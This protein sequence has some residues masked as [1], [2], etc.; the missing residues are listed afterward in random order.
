MHRRPPGSPGYHPEDTVHVVRRDELR[1]VDNDGF[2]TVEPRHPWLIV[3][4]RRDDRLWDEA[5]ADWDAFDD[6]LDRLTMDRDDAITTAHRILGIEEHP[7][8]P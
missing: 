2:Y 7:V 8:R 6:D 3:H 4:G 5:L 1:A